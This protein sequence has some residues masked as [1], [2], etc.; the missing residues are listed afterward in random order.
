M[1]VEIAKRELRDALRPVRGGD[2][3]GDPG[4]FDGDDIGELG[5]EDVKELIHRLEVANGIAGGVE[6]KSDG[7]LQRHDGLLNSFNWRQPER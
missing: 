7:I 1:K 2:R 4:A 5:A 6:D 3:A